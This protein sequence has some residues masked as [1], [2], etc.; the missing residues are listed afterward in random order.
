M[1]YLIV[2]DA[3]SLILLA[4][5]GILEKI[6]SV[7]EVK[8]TTVVKEECLKDLSFPDAQ[9]IQKYILNNKIKVKLVEDENRI[10][11]GGGERSAIQLYKE[12]NADAILTDDGKTIKY[13]KLMNYKYTT[14]PL[15]LISLYKKH[16]INKESALNALK[17]LEFEGRY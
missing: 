7:V 8:T 4:K 11:L 5:A 16:T 9:V 14:A 12:E 1:V 3:C 10:P 15:I 17:K 2:A 6:F 13:C